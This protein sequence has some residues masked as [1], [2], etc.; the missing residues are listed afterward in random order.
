MTDEPT[1]AGWKYVVEHLRRLEERSAK[2]E[3][4]VKSQRVMLLLIL[5]WLVVTGVQWMVKSP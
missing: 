2:L 4:L 3:A 5:L 1:P